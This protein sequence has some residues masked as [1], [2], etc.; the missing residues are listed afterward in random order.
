MDVLLW[1]DRKFIRMDFPQSVDKR[2][3][4]HE[5]LYDASEDHCDSCG[6][7]KASW[8]RDGIHRVSKNAPTLESCNFD[9][10][11]LIWMI[12]GKLHQHTFNLVN[13]P[14]PFTFTYFI[15]F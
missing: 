12:L 15:Y 8:W 11:T 5:Y 2:P 1:K 3:K 9:K 13:F 6:W 4:R 7:Q 10:H 14:W